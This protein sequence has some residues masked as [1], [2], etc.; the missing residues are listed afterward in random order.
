MSVY[1][2]K[3]QFFVLY[4]KIKLEMFALYANVT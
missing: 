2:E 3:G 4:N 1:T